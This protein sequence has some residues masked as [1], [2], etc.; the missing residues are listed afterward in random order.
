M[1]KFIKKNNKKVLKILIKKRQFYNSNQFQKKIFILKK[2]K[3]NKKI[4]KKF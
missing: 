2:A 3:N 4:F 1:N